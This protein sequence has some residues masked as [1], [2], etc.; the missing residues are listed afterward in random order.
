MDEAMKLQDS[1]FGTTSGAAVALMGAFYA[2]FFALGRV[3][4]GGILLSFRN[5]PT[6]GAGEKRAIKDV[7]DPP[8]M[9]PVHA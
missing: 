2:L 8:P 9:E 3:T 1:F 4:T 6:I 5:M 7:S